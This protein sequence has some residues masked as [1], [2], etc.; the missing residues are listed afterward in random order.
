MW[1]LLG[2]G[3]KNGLIAGCLLSGWIA[4]KADTLLTRHNLLCSLS[5]MFTE[6]RHSAPDPSIPAITLD[7]RQFF[8]TYAS[9]FLDHYQRPEDLILVHEQRD[10]RVPTTDPRALQIG[11]AM[12]LVGR[13][14]D[15]RELLGERFGKLGRRAQFAPI[16]SFVGWHP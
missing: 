11:A 16:L 15:A 14:G 1:A 6:R 5:R 8:A 10:K 7:L 12:L 4:R 2:Q 13:T 3:A 9:S